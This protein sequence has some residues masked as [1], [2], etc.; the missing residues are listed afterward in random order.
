[1]YVRKMHQNHIQR[2]QSCAPLMLISYQITGAK[3]VKT[4]IVKL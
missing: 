2:F 1:M 4:E 3:I